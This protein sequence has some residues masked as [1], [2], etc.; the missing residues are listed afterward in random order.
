M[1]YVFNLC[2]LYLVVFVSALV[3]VSTPVRVILE[4]N[5][6]IF[7]SLFICYIPFIYIPRSSSDV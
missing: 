6:I 4:Y 5:L 2:S 1:K 7:I 3:V